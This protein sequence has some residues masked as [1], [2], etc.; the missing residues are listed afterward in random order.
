ME[1]LPLVGIG[2]LEFGQRNKAV[3][4]L[5]GTPSTMINEN[6]LQAE[7]SEKW[8]Y[9]DLGIELSLENDG[10]QLLISLTVV[11]A[12]CLSEWI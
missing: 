6:G 8:E 10:K 4:K 5:L 3:L 1:I 12:D 7:G 9:N 11:S 2:E